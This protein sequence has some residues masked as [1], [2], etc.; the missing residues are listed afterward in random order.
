MAHRI[1]HR[2][3]IVETDLIINLK[4]YNFSKKISEFVQRNKLSD[5]GDCGT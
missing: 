3:E 5:P 1:V 2:Q 4:A